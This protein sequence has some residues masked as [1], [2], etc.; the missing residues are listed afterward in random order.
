MNRASCSAFGEFDI[1]VPSFFCCDLKSCELAQST[2]SCKAHLSSGN[3][4]S[5]Y[6]PQ[7]LLNPP[8]KLRALLQCRLSR[9]GVR[10]RA[11]RVY[12]EELRRY[13]RLATVG[14]GVLAGKGVSPDR[15]R[16]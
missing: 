11:L 5:G 15:N 7:T 12:Y 2:L 10:D 13:D 9:C 14:N 6:R 4:Q 8:C 1:F 3:P 16:P